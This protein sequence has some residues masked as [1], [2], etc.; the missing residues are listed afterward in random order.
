MERW[1]SEIRFRAEAK[2]GELLRKMEKTGLRRKKG[3]VKCSER[4][5]LKLSDLGIS[6]SQSL[7]W[8]ELGEVLEKTR[9]A[10][11]DKRRRDQ[12]T[13]DEPGPSARTHHPDQAGGARRVSDP[14]RCDPRSAGRSHVSRSRGR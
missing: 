8:Q 13:S 3:W 2:A 9:E 4:Q 10:Y 7:R 12:E 6:R 1:A 14:R 5:H 11:L